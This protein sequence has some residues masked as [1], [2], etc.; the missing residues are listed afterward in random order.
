MI[1][2]NKEGVIKRCLEPLKD[3]VDEINIVDKGSTDRAKEIVA[4]F[5]DRVFDFAAA[6]NF[7]FQQA[8]KRIY[9]TATSR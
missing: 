3:I 6:R 7:A 5:T 1:V 9:F 4:Q 8:T 2:K